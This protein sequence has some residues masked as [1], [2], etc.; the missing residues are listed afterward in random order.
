[1]AVHDQAAREQQQQQPDHKP[2]INTASA[3]G[4]ASI[5]GPA[6]IAVKV[7]GSETAV[8]WLDMTMEDNFSSSRSST[9]DGCLGQ[10]Q[11][12]SNS[13]TTPAVTVAGGGVVNGNSSSVRTGRAASRRL[14]TAKQQ[15]QQHF[16]ETMVSCS[17]LILSY[18]DQANNMWVATAHD[19]AV[20]AVLS[21]AATGSRADQ[22]V[23][24]VMAWAKQ[25]Q[26]QLVRLKQRVRSLVQG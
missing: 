14:I 9:H 20:V 7:I 15:P 17:S 19:T 8:D 10:Q 6:V 4:S 2:G 13:S 18:R 1:M 3:D 5:A 21:G 24:E 23:K 16:Q 25:E 26:Q 12:T 22:S 11:Q